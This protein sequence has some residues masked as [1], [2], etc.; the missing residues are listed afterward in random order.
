MVKPM[1]FKMIA[2]ENGF[3]INTRCHYKYFQT[4]MDFL[5]KEINSFNF[6]KNR[7]QKKDMV[8]F[9]SIIK[10]PEIYSISST[11]YEQ[12]ERV[13]DLIY[14][15]KERLSRIYCGYDELSKSEKDLIKIEAGDIKQG[16]VEYINNIVNTEPT[17][18]LLLKSIEDKKHRSI[19]NLIFTTLFGTPNKLFFTMIMKNTEPILKLQEDSHGDITI[20]DYHFCKISV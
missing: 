7:D 3:E 18:Y 6:R 16:C 15:T 13:L 1:F 12:K 19:S 17:M 10:T 9:S 2:K 8:P 11:Y 4:P 20:F 5:Q 14:A